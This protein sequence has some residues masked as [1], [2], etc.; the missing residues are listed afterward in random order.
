MASMGA[1]WNGFVKVSE[2]LFEAWTPMFAVLH[3]MLRHWEA[4]KPRTSLT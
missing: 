1:D 3:G 4:I 2:Y